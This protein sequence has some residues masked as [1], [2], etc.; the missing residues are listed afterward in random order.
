MQ[1]TL[2]DSPSAKT[3]LMP[4]FDNPSEHIC[5]LLVRHGLAGFDSQILHDFPVAEEACQVIQVIWC[6]HP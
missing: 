4:H 6:K 5:G 1:L 2:N 3:A